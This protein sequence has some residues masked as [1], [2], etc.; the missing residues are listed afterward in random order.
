MVPEA[1]EQS[2]EVSGVIATKAR[3][4]QTPW[5]VNGTDAEPS[6][7]HGVHPRIREQQEVVRLRRLKVLDVD[8]GPPNR[9]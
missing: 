7:P 6:G 4:I 5:D 9:R 3:F 1:S 8:G 2:P